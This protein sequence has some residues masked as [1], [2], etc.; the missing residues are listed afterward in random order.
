[1]RFIIRKTPIA[2]GELRPWRTTLKSQN[3]DSRKS[4]VTLVSLHD[5]L[6]VYWSTMKT[7]SLARTNSCSCSD[8]PV[9]I[10]PYLDQ[11]SSV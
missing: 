2:G 3:S 7:C 10:I 5:L 4:S 11:A 9:V 8:S 6:A 1:M